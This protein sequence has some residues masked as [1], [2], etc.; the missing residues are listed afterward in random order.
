[1]VFGA[2]DTEKARPGR[3]P[4][5]CALSIKTIADLAVWVG[6]VKLATVTTTG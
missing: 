1:M 4:G 6:N 5:L 3:P 2:F